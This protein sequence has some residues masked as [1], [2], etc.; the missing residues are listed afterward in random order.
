VNQRLLHIRKGA[1]GALVGLMATGGIVAL[2][3]APAGASVGVVTLFAA[4]SKPT[5][6]AGQSGA[7]AGNWTFTIPNSFVTGDSITIEVALPGTAVAQ[8]CETANDS[9]GFAST[10]SGTVV[11][12]AIHTGT[13]T[14][15][16]ITSSLSTA[17]TDGT[18]VCAAQSVKDLLTLT[19][20]NTASGAL[21]DTWNITIGGTGSSAITYTIGSAVAPGDVP[22]QLAT[23]GTTYSAYGAAGTSNASVSAVNVSA[24]SPAVSLS[25]AGSISNVTLTELQPEAVSSGGTADEFVCLTL[26]GGTWTAPDST[27]NVVTA[28]TQTGASAVSTIAAAGGTLSFKATPAGSPTATT[29]TVTDASLATISGT[30]GPVALTVTNATTAG[31]ATAN[32]LATGVTAYGVTPSFNRVWGQDAEGTAVAQFEQ[33][34]GCENSV[35]LAQDG[36]FSDALAASYLAGQLDTGVLLTNPVTLS[37]E[38]GQAIAT[39]GVKTVYIVGGPD[40]VSSGIMTGLQST[41]ATSCGGAATATDISV[42]RIFGNTADDTAAAIATCTTT[43][44]VCPDG[45]GTQNLTA[46]YTTN[47]YND[48]QGG[49]SS[50]PS[51]AGS[52]R[53]AI[54]ASDS[55]FQD[56]DTAGALA[57]DKHFPVLIT[58][59]T[60]LSSQV[61]TAIQ[62]LGIQQVILM[63]GQFAVQNAV[64]SA[65]EAL[66]GVSVVRVAGQDYT[67]TAQLLA[68]LELATPTGS[69]TGTTTAGFGWDDG[70]DVCIARGDYFADSLGAGPYCGD[71]TEP[72][73]FTIDP[74]TIGSYTGV[75]LGTLGAAHSVSGLD[76]FGGVLAEAASTV[77]QLQDDVAQG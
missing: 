29:F 2:G 61:S 67:D 68:Q 6:S 72:L 5:V 50:A 77:T 48:T 44:S 31:C 16:A 38:T 66:P 17:V 49:Q 41:L 30:A 20:N 64:S 34:F 45:I 58:N 8:G 10:P 54:V 13:D 55:L 18:H 39:E 1:I 11:S 65:L 53:T 4:S 3:V 14:V 15:P 47:P 33:N 36:Y 62:N 74:N 12:G 57:Y 59:P 42:Q 24:N 22:A 76:V 28:S 52:L 69:P 40:A 73:L 9:V 26:A 56:A 75:L 25:A 19:F 37:S 46:L 32:T 21:T 35:V 23:G 43:P 27:H 60:S 63:G 70:G 71:N 51:A 7:A